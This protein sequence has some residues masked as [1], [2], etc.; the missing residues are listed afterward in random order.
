MSNLFFVF[1]CNRTT[2]FPKKLTTF[3]TNKFQKN[4][5]ENSI[6]KLCFLVLN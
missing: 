2:F 1:L 4:C 3:V 6:E 5:T